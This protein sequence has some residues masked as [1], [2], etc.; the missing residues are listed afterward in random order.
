MGGEVAGMPGQELFR[1]VGWHVPIAV[2]V[3]AFTLV[4]ARIADRW[5]R[6]MQ[7]GRRAAARMA[8][9]AGFAPLAVGW[10]MAAVLVVAALDR[11]LLVSHLSLPDTVVGTALV[12]A[13]LAI[14]AMLALGLFAR[15]AAGGLIVLVVWSFAQ[16]GVPAVENVFFLGVGFFLF[17]WGRGRFAL[18]AVFS[19]IVFAMDTAHMKPVALSVLR[20]MTGAALLWAGIGVFLHPDVRLAALAAGTDPL[21][22]IRDFWPSLDAGLLVFVCAAGEL[23]AAFL[24]LFGWLL[25]PAALCLA[26]LFAVAAL[27]PSAGGFV[28]HLPYMVVFL[29]FVLLGKSAERAERLM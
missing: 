25:R 2:G 19:R 11:T 13:E 8:R 7:L 5:M 24:L 6:R 27:F 4:I 23:T 26:V 28:G 29:G 22:V 10:A 1:S 17:V 20:I 12:I 9:F 18:G 15:V 16:F 21:V 3:G 14:A